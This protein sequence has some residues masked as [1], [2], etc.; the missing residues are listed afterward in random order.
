MDFSLSQ[1]VG[2]QLCKLSQRN[3]FLT[4]FYKEIAVPL[5]LEEMHFFKEKKQSFFMNSKQL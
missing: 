1:K 3:L 2:E 5:L 4:T